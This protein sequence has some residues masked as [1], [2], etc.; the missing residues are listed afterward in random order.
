MGGSSS[1]ELE[2][3][4]LQ[5]RKLTR[6]LEKVSRKVAQAAPASS[7]LQ[8]AAEKSA[9]EKAAAAA[10]A[11]EQKAR[12]EL[13]AKDRE[14][15][16]TAMKL[17][18]M[19]S[20]LPK[21]KEV[22]QKNAQ[23]LESVKREKAQKDSQLKTLKDELKASK[24]ELEA[25]FGKLKFAEAE[26]AAVRRL[27]AELSEKETLVEQQR[28]AAEESARA[29][30]DANAAILAEQKESGV[31]TEAVHHPVFGQ[32]LHDYGHKKLF[33]GSPTTLWA[34]TVLW[35]R[36]RAF[37]QERAALIATAKGRSQSGWPGSISIVEMASGSDAAEPRAV[38][39]WRKTKGRG[40][41]SAADDDGSDDG[42]NGGGSPASS[43]M[44]IDGQHRLGAA[45]LLSARQLSGALGHPGG[46]PPMEEANIK[47]LF[48]EINKAEPVLLVDLQTAAR[49]DR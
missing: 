13:L 9:A 36:Q 7:A 18:G 46:Y 42:S 32:L 44:L 2:A 35:E 33:L 47:E 31:P 21:I 8:A 24:E 14:L 45:H 37:R 25:L 4:Q 43:L 49:A 34:G 11:A 3:A 30:A 39:R 5:V 38:A 23:E 40:R 16:M 29:I 27:K 20:E 12:E 19:A 22:A 28:A 15:E 17:K 26:G 6:E 48:T 41:K 10:A 1:R